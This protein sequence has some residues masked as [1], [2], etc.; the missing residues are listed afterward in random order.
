MSIWSS[1]Y[2]GLIESVR[3][4]YPEEGFLSLK[5]VHGFNLVTYRFHH[6]YPKAI[7]FLFHGMHMSSYDFTHVGKSLHDNGYTVAA[8]DQESHGKSEGE[9]GTITSLE[10][11][12]VNCEKFIL[13][14][15]ELYPENTPVFC[16]GLSMGGSLSVMISLK[17]PDLVNGVILFGASLAVDPNFEPMLQKI[18]RCLN[19]C[20]CG[21]LR[22]KKIDQSLVSRNPHYAGYFNENPEFF[23]EKLNVKT[24]V[25]MLNGFQRLQR[26]LGNFDKPVLMFHGE[27][28]KLASCEQAK[29]FIRICKS[30]DKEIVVYPD[31]FHVVT[32]EPEFPEII[33]K[34]IAWLNIR[35]SS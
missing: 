29:E 2:E 4:A 26:Q 25:A 14:T 18:V 20:C 22:L 13:K 19:S 16:L 28:D 31:M 35:T 11:Y 9:K 17:R 27:Q 3:F 23:H 34:T 32:H 1:K 24:A 5:S 21:G 15:K 30:N 8:F 33:E 6:D 10:D 12:C 7:V